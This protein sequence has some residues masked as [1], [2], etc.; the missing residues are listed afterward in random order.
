MKLLPPLKR[1]QVTQTFGERPEFYKKFGLKGHDGTDYRTRWLDYPLAH[2]EVFASHD[3]VADVRWDKT[4][5]GTH[6]RLT[7]KECMTI[8]GHMSKAV[9][10]KGQIVKA[11]QLLG[12]TGNTGLTSGPHLHFEVRMFPLK[13]KN[14]YF[15]AVDAE[16]FLK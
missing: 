2:M 8:Y 3:G 5:Y 1:L 12:Y 9:V 14:G 15:G 16:P 4:G 13:E 6:V 7:G 10:A 11:G